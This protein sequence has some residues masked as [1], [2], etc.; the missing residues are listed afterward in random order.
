ML[1]QFANACV[2]IKD[3]PLITQVYVSFIDAG[4]D[5]SKLNGIPCGPKVHPP[6]VNFSPEPHLL[7]TLQEYLLQGSY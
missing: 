4:T 7:L 6:P 2:Y 1:Q 3:P 5:L